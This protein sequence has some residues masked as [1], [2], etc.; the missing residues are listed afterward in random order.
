MSDDD[1][2]NNTNYMYYALLDNMSMALCM[3]SS[4]ML[5]ITML[6]FIVV[7]HPHELCIVNNVIGTI[8][9]CISIILTTSSY[10]IVDEYFFDIV[11]G[12]FIF[13]ILQ[14]GSIFARAFDN[15][16]RLLQIVFLTFASIISVLT[17]A[18]FISF[19]VDWTRTNTDETSYFR[20]AAPLTLSFKC[21]NPII[22][23]FAAYISEKDITSWYDLWRNERRQRR[24][25]REREAT[26][27]ERIQNEINT[28]MV[29]I[30]EVLYDP[31]TTMS[32]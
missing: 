21:L 7:D 19:F 12:L 20:V 13:E 30:E 22:G 31:D 26:E 4:S 23:T 24:F 17:S 29:T 1:D 18:L 16:P 32:I 9:V 11:Y 27:R 14:I 28:E 15:S 6:V 3:A 2:V 8:Q 5:C 25:I 10:K